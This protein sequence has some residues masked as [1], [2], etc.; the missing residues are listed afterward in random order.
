ME[1]LVKKTI[2]VIVPAYNE[3]DCID[4]LIHRCK[5]V[6][7]SQPKYFFELI[8]I[9][10]G[11]KDKTWEKIK[12]NAALDQRI[13]GVKLSRNFGMDGGLTAGLSLVKTDACIFMTADLQDPP[14]FIPLFIEKWEM[15][16]ENI[17]GI[18][19]SRKKTNIFRKI[20]SQL[21]Y[22]LASILSNRSIP[23]NV[24][25]FR[26]LD[27]KVY[28]ALLELNEKNRFM[29]GLSAWVGFNSIGISLERPP[30]FAGESKALTLRTIDFAIRGILA[31]SYVPLR[32]IFLFGILFFATNFLIMILVIINS[33][34]GI[35]EVSD[36][37]LAGSL[38]SFLI[39]ILFLFVG[40]LSEYIGLIY[41]ETKSR[42]TFIIQ[43]IL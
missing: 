7:D 41:E 22:F 17:Y 2:S 24:S 20:N 14:E 31:Y 36:I 32:L 26:L 29:R 33:L 8:L 43:E 1:N 15:G 18:I 30:R 5:S 34:L 3:E 4:E 6:F 27:K 38:I 10:N 21:F 25:D 28:Q 16:F 23:K 9:E 42:S 37:F 40:F 39:S 19:K 35:F 13:R 12:H 11:S